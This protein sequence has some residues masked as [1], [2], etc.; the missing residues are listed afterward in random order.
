MTLAGFWVI[1]SIIL[2]A[3]VCLCV[4]FYN[5]IVKGFDRGWKTLL[6]L[7]PHD[8]GYEKATHLCIP[9]RVAIETDS[10]SGFSDR[11]GGHFSLHA[12][13]AHIHVSIL[14]L[15]YSHFDPISIPIGCIEPGYDSQHYV[16]CH[17]PFTTMVLD[18]RSAQ[19][20]RMIG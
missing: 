17:D 9:S 15:S 14:M 16:I 2:I 7:F 3:F 8:R 12:D 13:S 10:G 5:F 11:M 1:L 4:L 6:V 19:G 20:V 18:E